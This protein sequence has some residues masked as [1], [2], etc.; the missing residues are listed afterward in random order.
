LPY[1]VSLTVGSSR[2]LLT[3]LAIGML[4][5]GYVELKVSADHEATVRFAIEHN[6]HGRLLLDDRLSISVPA[7][8]P[9]VGGNSRQ[10]ASANGPLRAPSSSDTC[11][12][13][14]Q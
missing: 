5:S 4:I 14:S 8:L 1:E 7:F 2:F 6:Y 10:A 11:K 13:A 9:G 3:L 12:D